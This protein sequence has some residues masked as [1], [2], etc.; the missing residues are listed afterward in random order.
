MPTSFFKGDLY[1]TLIL[2]GKEPA[3]KII[4]ELTLEVEHLKAKNILPTFCVIEVG[5]DPAS[6]IYLRLK[7]KLAKKIGINE[8]T[9]KF[10][11]DIRQ[12]ELIDKI[13]ELNADP[14]VDAIMV[15]LPIPEH[16]NTRLVLE[17]IDP[18][19]DADGFTPYNQGRMWQGQVN[20][21][22]ATVRSIMT[23]LDYYQ[24]NVEGKNALII[25]RSIIVGKPVASQLLAR[26][27]TVTIAHSHTR[28][29]QE[30]TLLNDIIIS[31]VGRAHLITKNMVKSGS[32]LIDV[33]MN[34]ENGK[35]MGD[36]EYDDCLPI[37]EAITPVPGG[38]GPLTVANLMKQVIILTKLRHN[39]GN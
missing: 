30:L 13:K 33:G 17:A 22:P 7:R 9:I 19:K 38:V 20:I 36:I 24:L 26:N 4:D 2:D 31:D 6:K 28:K 12:D 21:I 15:Q 39:Y 5:E 23:I 1:L 25:G 35:L 10:P 16:I 18:A 27:A 29:L 14:H 11:G 37:A 32:I 3:K 34:R 8:Q